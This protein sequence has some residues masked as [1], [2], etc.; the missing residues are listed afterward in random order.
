[1]RMLW[2]VV[3]FQATRTDFGS[4][5]TSHLVLGLMSAWLVG[6]GRYWDNTRVSLPEHLGLGSVLYVFVL[7]GFLFASIAPLRPERWTYRNLLTFISLTAAPGLIYA[8]PVERFLALES[9]RILNAGFLGLVATWRVAL[10]VRYLRVH[11]ELRWPAVIVGAAFPLCFV[12]AALWVLNLDRVVFDLMAGIE[13]EQSGDTKA[14]LVLTWLT[15][16]A[17]S[18]FTPLLLAYLALAYQAHRR[19]K[20]VAA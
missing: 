3:T 1:V 10:L 14:Y 7:A 13:D 4:L 16:G 18:L 6:V 12:V 8:I 9:A 5:G 17:Y 20:G 11:G 15:F 2:R 19:V